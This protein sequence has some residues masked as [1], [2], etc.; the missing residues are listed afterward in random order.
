MH[1]ALA[2]TGLSPRL[3][4]LFRVELE[5]GNT[6]SDQGGGAARSVASLP[7]RNS[8]NCT[9]LPGK[10]STNGRK[11]AFALEQNVASFIKVSGLGRVGFLTLTFAEHV[12]DRKEAQKRWH[13]LR[14]H[15]LKNRYCRILRVF[16]RQKSGRIHFHVLVALQDDIRT[17]FSFDEARGKVYRSANA[18]LR[19]EWAFW[20][21][22]APRFRF[23][24]TELLPIEK[25]EAMGSY[26]GKYI[27]KHL[28]VRR[29]DDKGARLVQCS[30]GWKVASSTFSFNSPGAWVWRSKLRYWAVTRGCYSLEHVRSRFGR[31]WA[32]R[33]R[34][35]IHGMELSWYPTG[36]HARADGLA[37]PLDAYDIRRGT[38]PTRRILPRI[39][40][41]K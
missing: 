5:A 14:T 27:A 13:S 23:G 2:K 16:E 17:G 35:D 10:T 38:A 40:F 6:A 41:S 26:V 39:R 21:K 11:T 30:A 19:R 15:I 34:D 20:R 3:R 24:R 31:R 4:T 29:P 33:Y 32:H 12:T 8:N 36:A 1:C 22:T 7:C 37:Y 9:D 18:A 28:D 25:P